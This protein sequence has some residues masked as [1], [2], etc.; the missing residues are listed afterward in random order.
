MFVPSY[1]PETKYQLPSARLVVLFADFQSPS[2]NHK[3][4]GLLVVPKSDSSENLLFAAPEDGAILAI[5][6]PFLS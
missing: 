3:L 1:V 4:I 2:Y 6:A 5:A